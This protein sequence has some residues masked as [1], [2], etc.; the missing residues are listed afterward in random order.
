MTLPGFTANA[1]L[2]DNKGYNHKTVPSKTRS[3][4]RIIP[5][6]PYWGEP[7]RRENCVGDG[8]RKYSAILWGIDGSWERACRDTPARIRNADGVVGTYHTVAC[9]NQA[10][11]MWGI[12]HVPES[13]CGPGPRP[14]R[15]YCTDR[16]Y[17]TE[18]ECLENGKSWCCLNPGG[19][20]SC[21]IA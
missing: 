12:F 16:Q 6:A 11:N 10:F 15:C 17:V 14:T 5:A 18:F 9:D 3:A 13:S 21:S 1:S 8:K 7:F 2:T 19:T 20:V 4:E